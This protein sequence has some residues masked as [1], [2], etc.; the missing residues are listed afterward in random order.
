MSPG[1]AYRFDLTGDEFDPA[2]VLRA[3]VADLRRGVGTGA[4]AAGFHVAV[5]HL[6]GDVGRAS[7]GRARASTWSP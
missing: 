2:P 3:L 7:S 5:A 1:A 4:M 6:V